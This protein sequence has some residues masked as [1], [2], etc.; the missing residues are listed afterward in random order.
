M[1]IVRRK[2]AKDRLVYIS[3]GQ[4]VVKTPS[5]CTRWPQELR[6]QLVRDYIGPRTLMTIANY[7]KNVILRGYR[8]TVY[9]VAGT[10]I[11]IGHPYET[12]GKNQIV[13]LRTEVINLNIKKAM[14]LYH[15]DPAMRILMAWSFI[16]DTP[17]SGVPK[18]DV[19]H[20]TE[21]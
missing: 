17:T 15:S 7:E 12:V 21:T 1:P 6:L 3:K 8:D 10:K 2:A 20:Y 19:Y 14:Y 18:M 9:K 11:K 13:V 5:E 16:T 4:L